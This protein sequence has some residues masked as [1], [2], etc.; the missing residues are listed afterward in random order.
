M[1]TNPIIRY[2][3]PIY[4]G[5]QLRRQLDLPK[6]SAQA[7]NEPRAAN[8]QGPTP[9]TRE[10]SRIEVFRQCLENGLTSAEDIARKMGV[11][12]GTVSK[13]AKRAMNEGWCRKNGRQYAVA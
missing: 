4:E 11:S 7:A 9:A 6:A 5:G 2:R 12:K 8:E 13:L 10:A 3:H 1:S